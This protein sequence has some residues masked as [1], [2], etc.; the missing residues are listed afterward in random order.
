MLQASNGSAVAL[1]RAGVLS[2]ASNRGNLIEG[3]PF[4]LTDM[5]HELLWENP[6]VLLG[7]TNVYYTD[8]SPY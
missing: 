8:K 3:F 1:M 6:Q 4:M 5:G 2:L 7:T